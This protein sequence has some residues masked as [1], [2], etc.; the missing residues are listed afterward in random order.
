MLLLLAVSI[1]GDPGVRWSQGFHVN[2]VRASFSMAFGGDIYV[3]D[4]EDLRVVRTHSGKIFFTDF[5][6]AGDLDE[7]TVLTCS[8][9]WRVE[10]GSLVFG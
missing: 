2:I 1:L 7:W 9:S 8:G 6:R 10:G 3:F 4:A 5:D